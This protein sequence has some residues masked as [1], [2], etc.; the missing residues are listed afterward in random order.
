MSSFIPYAS[1]ASVVSNIPSSSPSSEPIVPPRHTENGF[2]TLRTAYPTWSALRAYLTSGAGGALKVAFQNE[3]YALV[4]YVKGQSN[5]SLPH[6]RLFRSV[7]WD[8][9]D[10]LPVSVTAPKSEDGESLPSEAGDFVVTPFH[11]GVL[12]GQF[13]CK[14][15]GQTL[16]HTRTYFG[17]ANTFYSKKTF[18]EMF[19]EAVDSSL[20]S[21]QQGQSFTYVLQHPENRVVTPVVRP[22]AVCVHVAQVL[23]DGVVESSPVWERAVSYRRG[24]HDTAGDVLARYNAGGPLDQGVCVLSLGTDYKRF[25][26]RKPAYNAIRVLR[27]NNASLDYTWLTLWQSATIH[28]YLKAYPEEKDR[29]HALMNA[30]KTATGEVFRYYEDVFKRHTL[31]MAQA[32]RKYKP[33]L[34]ELHELYKSTRTP[35]AWA[36][37]KEFMNRRDVPQMLSILRWDAR[38]GATTAAAATTATLATAVSARAAATTATATTYTNLV[39]L[40]TPAIIAAD[41]AA[42]EAAA[43]AEAA[44]AAEDDDTDYSDMPAL[45]HISE[46]QGL[47]PPASDSLP[48]PRVESGPVV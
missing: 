22:R 27:G 5:L 48:V 4:H 28:D 15:T 25:K 36:A 31:T 23:P 6:V 14:Y 21:P 40:A 33:L 12:V 41:A 26:V 46:L 38:N 20:L 1:F 3:H 29:A 19:A 43:E 39:V 47:P 45:I 30:W 42:A 32:P 8:V 44:V 11:D 35:I 9:I 2:K 24:L 10:N 16:M 7:V 13:H 18:G 34:Y 37:C 17:G